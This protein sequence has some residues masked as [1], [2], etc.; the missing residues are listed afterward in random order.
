MSDRPLTPAQ[1]LATLTATSHG[2][3]DAERAIG[4]VQEH[5]ARLERMRAAAVKVLTENEVGPVVP[6]ALVQRALG[7]LGCGLALP[8]EWT[9]PTRK[10]N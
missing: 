1:A 10:A 9:R 2:D 5:I 3:S 7:E 6:V 8:A 4:I